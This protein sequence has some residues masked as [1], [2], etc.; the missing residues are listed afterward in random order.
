MTLYL[1]DVCPQGG[2]LGLSEN[3]G[4]P[5]KI[6]NAMIKYDFMMINHRILPISKHP[7]HPKEASLS[8]FRWKHPTP[9]E[10]ANILTGKVLVWFRQSMAFW[11]HKKPQSTTFHFASPNG[12]PQPQLSWQGKGCAHNGSSSQKKQC[13]PEGTT[14]L[15]G[16]CK[17]KRDFF[18]LGPSKSMPHYLRR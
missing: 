4:I 11:L 9:R 10:W 14:A 17:H 13:N 12:Q 15:L 2:K 16:F 6:A 18:H 8:K 1:Q 7:P 5:W 3:W